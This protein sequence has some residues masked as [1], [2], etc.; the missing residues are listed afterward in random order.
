MKKTDQI[1]Q[2]R[3]LWNSLSMDDKDKVDPLIR[4]GLQY[5]LGHIILH[6]EEDLTPRLRRVLLDLYEGKRKII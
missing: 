1:T 6:H 5:V 2:D 4:E 3:P